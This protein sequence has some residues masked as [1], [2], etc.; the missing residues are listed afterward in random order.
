MKRLVIVSGALALFTSTAFATQSRLLA[1]G[2]KET[3]NEGLYYIQDSRNIFQNPANINLFSNQLVM[4]YGKYGRLLSASGS[5]RV[6]LDTNAKPKAQGG[7]VKRYGDLN[8][9]FYYGNESNTSALLRLVGTSAAAAANGTLG[10][11]GPSA[12]KQLQSADNQL[13]FFVGGDRDLKWGANLVLAMGKDETNSAKNSAISSRFGVMD[14]K[15]DAHLNVSMGSKSSATD[16]V[17]V[18]GGATVSSTTINHEFKGKLGVQVGGSY[19]LNESL[20]AFG[21]IKHYSWE[22]S[23]DYAYSAGQ[24]AVLGGQQGLVKGDFTS[25]YAGITQ[26]YSFN[27]TDK[28]FLTLSLKKQ[29]INMQFTNKG[30]VRHIVVPVTV[31]F[32]TAATEW[33]TFR[34]S[35]IQNVYGQKNNKNLSNLNVVARSVITSTYGANGKATLDNSTEVNAGA[36][37]KF[38]SVTIDGVVSTTDVARNAADTASSNVSDTKKGSLSLD[39]L[40]TRVALTYNF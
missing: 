39:N 14:K 24:I 12:S 40:M 37:L 29:D 38:G 33:L 16:T 4:E 26:D 20:R 11:S 18:S 8:Y 1:L 19:L 13:D 9:G 23:D 25:Y 17:A 28:V 6:T 7:F 22:Q 32:E 15:W 10:V 5:T 31:A 3:D 36:S 27:S 35:I 2:M 30:E 21:Y 34:G